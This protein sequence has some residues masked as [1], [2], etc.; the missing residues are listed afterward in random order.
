MKKIL[1][2]NY[3]SRYPDICNLDIYLPDTNELCPVFIYFHGGGLEGGNKNVS[4]SLEKIVMQNI[5]LVSV[6][7]RMYPNAKFPDFIEDA[8]KAIDYIIKYDKVHKLF[9]SYFVGGSSAGAYLSMM[10]YFDHRY[11]NQYEID[12]SSIKGWFFNAG[13]PTVHYRVL[14][15]RGFDTRLIRVDEAAPIY[16]INKDIDSTNQANLMFVIAEHDMVGRLEQTNLLLN[17]MKQFKY[18]TSKVSYKYMRGC[19]HC[20]YPIDDLVTE[21]I[22]ESLK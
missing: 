20:S 5:A 13:Q 19:N 14:K 2:L 7:Y 6:D 15:E 18:D 21:L 16:F 12:V 9:S 17:V 4:E 11:L 3:D 1:N 10:L 22:K 8:A